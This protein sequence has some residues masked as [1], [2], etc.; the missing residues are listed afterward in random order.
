MMRSA[1]ALLALA[2]VAAPLAAGA[3][4]AGKVYRIAYLGSMP[5]SS[6]QG[7]SNWDAFLRGL[8]ERSW[9]EGQNV[10]IESRYT[11]GRPERFPEL[12]AEVLRIQVDVIVVA[13]SQAAWAAKRATDTTPIV[14]A[15]VA[16]AVGQGLV[17]SLARPGGNIT[18]LSNQLEET[19]GRLIQALKDIVPRLARLAVV[20][21]PNNP[22]SHVRN[23]EA[24]ASRLGIKVVPVVFR[25]PDDLAPAFATIAR[26]RADGLLLH[27]ASPIGEHWPQFIEFAQKQ[28]LP[29]AGLT[30]RFVELGGLFYYG[31][32]F[33]D[34]WYRA[35]HYVDRVLR[36]T[37][38]A[39]LPVEQPTK[40][41]LMVNLKTAK[42]LGL[43][44]PQSVL[45]RADEVIE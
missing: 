1:V 14:L 9:I 13:D 17:A 24:A 41:L 34:L 11:Q 5:P 18:G 39:D 32:D 30:R 15:N 16:D 28:R 36:G 19:I 35:A 43:T 8:R 37:K 23:E 38:P 12:V 31:P 33:A 20:H 26:E 44:I 42:T 22:A 29:T 7:R 21:N 27:I 45:A 6:P 10:V 4:Q 40:F 3:Q 25:T 2:L